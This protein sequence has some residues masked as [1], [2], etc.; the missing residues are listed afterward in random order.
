[1]GAMVTGTHF[2][3]ADPILYIHDSSG[4]LGT[5]DVATGATRVIGN[6]GVVLT[7]IAFSSSGDLYGMSFTGF[8]RID[9][10]TAATAFIGNHGI[11]S[12]NAL[13]F[14]QEGIL[15]AAGGR[16]TSLFQIDPSTGDATALGN[17]GFSSA[18][19]LAF[20]NGIL[21]LSSTTDQLVRVSLSTYQGTAVGAIG[22]TEVFGLATGDDSVLYGVAG[23]EIF[24]LDA[25]TGVGTLRA[26]YQGRGLGPANGSSFALEAV[27]ARLVNLS[28]RLRVQTGENVVIGGSII[29]GSVPKRMIVRGIGPSLNSAGIQSPLSDPVLELYQGG[30]LVASNDDWRSGQQA[31]IAATGLAPGN[32]LEAALIR[33]LSPGAYTVIM[34]GYQDTT[35]IALVEAYDL[36]AGSPSQLG[37]IS[38]RGFVATGDNVMIG[39]FIMRAKESSTGARVVIRAVGPSLT[40]LGVM[41][42][43]QDPTLQLYNSSGTVVAS[44]DNWKATQRAEI[45]AAGLALN[46]DRESAILST[47]S[48]GSYTAIVRGQGNST[49]VGLVEIYYIGAP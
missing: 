44:N 10:Q 8:Y 1:M 42:A 17:M 48:P 36:D 32:D 29:T 7:D 22:F 33:T 35:G 25:A 34:R 31:E 16:S 24:S 41:G 13:V 3:K 2:A 46:D 47:L 43:L 49:G 27:A 26:D 11:P 39:G 28:T 19:D 30:T 45:E 40:S 18:G 38:T 9:P 6:M 23:T 21:Y 12:G 5:V 20:K 14:S 4:R 37:N 15:Y